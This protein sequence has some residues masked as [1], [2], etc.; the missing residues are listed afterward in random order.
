MRLKSCAAA[1]G[2]AASAVAEREQ[3]DLVADEQLLDDDRGARIA[4]GPADEAGLDGGHGRGAVRAD[5]DAL[6]G[7]EPVGLDHARPAEV[8]DCAACGL[9]VRA[10][11][12]TRR[13]HARSLHQLLRE[14]LRALD[15]RGTGRRAEDGDARASQ[16]ISEAEH[17]RQLGSDHDEPDLEV[18]GQRDQA[19]DVVDGDVVAGRD[20][21]DA[22]IAGRAMQVATGGARGERLR[23]RVLPPAR[24]DEQD[25][26]RAESTDTGDERRRD[27]RRRQQLELAG[28]HVVAAAQAAPGGRRHAPAAADVG[29]EV[30][31]LGAAEVV[32]A[33]APER[34]DH[35]RERA[36]APRQRVARAQRSLAVALA[37]D[38]T[39]ILEPAQPA[40]PADWARSGRASGPD[41]RSA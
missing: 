25:P 37:R 5:G 33:E 38:E 35:G 31:G 6:A 32:D 7:R 39:E 8:V 28:G 14:G 12:G 10:R 13:R 4:V 41:R 3:R 16:G 17:E 23:Q 36:A 15:A 9:D 27:L 18:V 21:R 20:A 1:S 2:R 34:D 24:T 19:A 40:R 22:G 29:R 26:H 30:V 11:H